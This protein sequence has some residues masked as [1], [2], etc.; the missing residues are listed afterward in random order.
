[1]N[2]QAIDGPGAALDE[3]ASDYGGVRG[4]LCAGALLL[5]YLGE[6]PGCNAGAC[7]AVSWLL[8]DAVERLDECARALEGAL[9]AGKAG[10]GAAGA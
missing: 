9:G 8:F 5:G 7:N 3:L 4:A 10:K 2:R 6:L 1:M